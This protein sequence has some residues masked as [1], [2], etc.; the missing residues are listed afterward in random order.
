MKI[1][2][3]LPYWNRQDAADKALAA[4]ERC[5]Q[6]LGDFE[7]I[8]VDDGSPVPFLPPKSNLDIRVITLPAK[9]EPKSPV[10]C[11]NAAATVA[12]GDILILSCIEVL[13]ETPVLESMLA[14]ILN[15]GE[16]A[17]VMAAAWCPEEK[18]WHTHSTVTVPDCPAD[19]GLGFCS[20]LAR[21]LYWKAGGFDD[22]YREGAGYED[23]DFILR[24]ARAGAQFV[25]RDDL[26][27]IHPK[28]GATIAWGTAKFERNL[29]LYRS[30]WPDTV[31]QPITVV[32]VKA[33]TAYGP[34]YVN[35][36]KDMVS[37]NLAAGTPGRFVC[38]TDDPTGIAP[39]IEILPLPAD[40]ETWYG[41]LYLFQRGLFK[42]G[43]RIAYFDLDTVITGPL[44]SIFKYRG[45]FA[46]L[47]DFYDASR[48]GPAIML[49]TP[50]DYTASIWDEWVAEGKP[51]NQLGDLWW[52]NRLDQGRFAKT[53]EKLQDLYPRAFASYKAHCNPY[54]PQAASV[55]CF[56]GQ[57]KPHNCGSSWV[58]SVWR[59]GG[60]C[61]AQLEV[62][63]NT[64]KATVARYIQENSL[65]PV[66]WMDLGVLPDA[67]AVIV[68]GGPS[69]KECLNELRYRRSV[70][71][72]IF[73][74]NNTHEYLVQQGI[75]PDA[76]VIIDARREN[77]EFIQTPA[78]HYYLASQCHPS[79]FV[80][81]GDPSKITLFHMNTDGVL[82]A[83][84]Q[85]GKPLHLLSGGTT[86]GLM[87]IALTYALG[88]RQ[89]H[90]FGMDSCYRDGQH[91]AY[92]QAINDD[93]QTV[94]VEVTGR[95]FKAA[96]WM[97]AQVQQFQTLAWQLI[98]E[99]CIITAAGDGLLQHVIRSMAESQE[100]A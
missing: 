42:D 24:L 52:L 37:R 57:P 4:L 7:V 80:K 71:Q 68:G 65:R 26:V 16:N 63:S 17:Y 99:G 61:A 60:A 58:E 87:T 39:D 45:Q 85:N 59:M 22:D 25:K 49:W 69:L 41:K 36:L 6:H 88:Y 84:P 38:V 34:E 94:D 78:K 89:F 35:I 62:V 72:M 23:R 33:G 100:A 3:L 97:A 75:L 48:V 2:L 70:G 30:K 50:S 43:E 92:A 66:K 47:R 96:A 18:R 91:H 90:L 51:R 74:L 40:L 1:S 31:P 5:Y 46:T 53:C 98:S 81:A 76:Q 82:D 79:V 14:E 19:A 9:T 67:H 44:D 15:R 28:S 32:C 8:V 54:P 64:A 56:H 12:R 10:T 73:A 20:M 83:I 11:W 86:V 13:H 93:D 27:V 21:K 95:K 55:V 29:A 77:A